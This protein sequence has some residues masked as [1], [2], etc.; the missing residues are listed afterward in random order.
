MSRV[1]INH[2]ALRRPGGRA[3][4]AAAL[5]GVLLAGAA[6]C[7][8]T[9]PTGDHPLAGPPRSAATAP[10]WPYWPRRVRIHPLTRL[11]EEEDGTTY[12]EVRVEF[13]DR[14]DD[15]T[16]ANGRLELALFDER[17]GPEDRRV[18]DFWDSDLTDETTNATRFDPVTR[19]YL[20]KLAVVA[21]VFDL[22][23]VLY[24][25][26]DSEDGR[27]MLDRMELRTDG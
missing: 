8:S 16:K 7:D 10:D 14:Q 15:G 4:S 23:P 6:G 17:R 13:L 25:R 3:T 2:I 26:H 21:E 22:G 20:F 9:P 12:V 27:T 11:V 18:I 24:V 1:S 19:T 5:L